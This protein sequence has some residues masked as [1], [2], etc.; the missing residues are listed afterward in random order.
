[1]EVLIF[2]IAGARLP[3]HATATAA[4]RHHLCAARAEMGAQLAT[5]QLSGIWQLAFGSGSG[6]GQ[7]LPGPGVPRKAPL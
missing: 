3:R 2:S 1:M 7:A 5:R 6:C 4:R